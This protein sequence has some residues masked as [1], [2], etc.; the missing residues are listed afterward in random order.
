MQPNLALLMQTSRCRLESRYGYVGRLGEGGVLS[1]IVSFCVS[2]THL[3]SPECHGTGGGGGALLST[4]GKWDQSRHDRG[5][6]AIV[7]TEKRNAR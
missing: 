1:L 4:L 3:L 5:D 6:L 2:R 7:I